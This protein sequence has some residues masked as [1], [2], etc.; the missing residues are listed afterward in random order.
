MNEFWNTVSVE[1]F[2]IMS[3]FAD[4]SGNPDDNAVRFLL[5]AWFFAFALII[6]SKRLIHNG[7]NLSHAFLLVGCTFGLIR[8]SVMFMLEYGFYRDFFH[9]IQIYNTFPMLDHT[10]QM[11]TILS[12]NLSIIYSCRLKPIFVKYYYIVY[13]IPFAMYIYYADKWAEFSK[14]SHNTGFTFGLFEGDRVYHYLFLFFIITTFM[15]VLYKWKMVHI[16]MVGFL[17]F[18]IAENV[19][20]L[21]SLNSKLELRYICDPLSHS[22]YLWAIPFLIY[23]IQLI[24][25]DEYCKF[26]EEKNITPTGL[27]KH[28]CVKN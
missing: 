22:F 24:P 9:N 25:T 10:F 19:Y 17:I 14:N 20:R 18:S 21:I 6:L 11:L 2:H 16:S 1:V 28:I 8:N 5:A 12:I 26:K 4:G 7:F 23:Y 13:T 3:Q 15:A 27:G